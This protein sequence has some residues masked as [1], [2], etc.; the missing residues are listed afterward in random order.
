MNREKFH[1]QIPENDTVRVDRFI[2]SLGLFSRSQIGRRSVNVKNTSGGELKLSRKLKDGDVIILEW[3]DPPSSEIN[4]E[5]IDLKIL[6]EDEQCVVIDKAQGVVVHPAY[7]HVHGTLVQGLLYRYKELEKNFGGDRVRP[8]IVHRLDKDT[9][10]LIIAAKDPES[11]DFLSGQFRERSV[12][13]TYLAVVRGTMPF[14]EGEIDEPIGRDP[15]DRKK[16]AVRTRNA[17]NALTR[18]RVLGES[19]G[20][21]LL[22]LRILTGRTHQIRV[23]LQSLGCPILGDPLYSRGNPEFPDATMMLH[24]W[25]LAIQLPGK[26]KTRFKS[27]IPLRFESLLPVLGIEV[28]CSSPGG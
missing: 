5:F 3:D 18:Y 28:P 11:L 26:G 19:G 23:H 25:K 6:Y 12:K 22:Q 1:V 17:K 13:K 9:S 2:A 21:S 15:R 27:D 24:S 4:P 20:Y 10:G 8:G 7:G 14:H 16:F